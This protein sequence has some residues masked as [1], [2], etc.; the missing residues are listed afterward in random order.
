MHKRMKSANDLRL[1]N[2]ESPRLKE[3][4]SSIDNIMEQLNNLKLGGLNT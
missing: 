4:S 3:R 2:E 1:L